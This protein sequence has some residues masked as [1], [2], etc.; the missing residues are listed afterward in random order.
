MLCANIDSSYAGVVLP[1]SH[2]I[3]R[4]RA[5]VFSLERIS[6]SLVLAGPTSAIFPIAVVGKRSPRTN[7][8]NFSHKYGEKNWT[9][10]QSPHAILTVGHSWIVP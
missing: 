3:L 7:S 1:Q 2:T 10:P 9:A 6:N 5:W 4:R 8:E